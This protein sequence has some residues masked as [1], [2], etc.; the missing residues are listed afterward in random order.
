MRGSHLGRN[1]PLDSLSAILDSTMDWP[2]GYLQWLTDLLS[3]PLTT[4]TVTFAFD[5]WKQSRGF[6]RECR[7]NPSLGMQEKLKR[8]TTE[9]RSRLNLYTTILV[10]SLGNPLVVPSR[11]FK[12]MISE[13]K[14]GGLCSVRRLEFLERLST[15]TISSQGARTGYN[16]DC[17]MGHQNIGELSDE[18]HLPAE[19][20]L[21]VVDFE[22][23]T[24]K[25][26]ERNSYTS[27]SMTVGE[28]GE[29]R[30]GTT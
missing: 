23:E 9:A 24:R 28:P 2:T 18:I 12:E 6:V 30:A 27:A 4:P 14:K 16:C 5:R 11:S 10:L 1:E 20:R 15:G 19:I 29:D 3:T 26:G 22:Y 8:L 7:H 25:L 17:N 21:T 13:L